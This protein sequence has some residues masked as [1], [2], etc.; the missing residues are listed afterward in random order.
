M[1]PPAAL[2]VVIALSSGGA[3]CGAERP[4]L[5]VDNLPPEAPGKT[6]RILPGDTIFV[7]V[8]DQPTMSGEFAVRDDGYY[9]QP[10]LGG[11]HV[12]GMTAGEARGV[13]A[14]RLAQIVVSPRVSLSIVRSRPIRVSVGG[15]VR[16]P[17][18]YEL[19]R[20]RRVLGAL[21]AAGWLTDYAD[22]EGI[23]VVRRGV[24]GGRI[25]FRLEDLKEGGSRASEFE[26][27]EGDVV[28]VE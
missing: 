12:A 13:V 11:I 20:N 26:L 5:W 22:A 17:G 2:F 14:N 1:T 10:S 9:V 27:H 6:A 8:Q 23:Y 3:G 21:T 28:I 18:N 25:R 15:E 19:D 24:P 7:E 16:T 4:F